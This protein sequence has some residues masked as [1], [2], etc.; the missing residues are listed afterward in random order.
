[1][2]GGGEGGR[3]W[4][5]WEEVERV[6]GGGEG[7]RRWRG[8]EEVERVGGGGEGGRRCGIPISTHFSCNVKVIFLV[9][10]EQFKELNETAERENHYLRRE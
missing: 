2:G 9:V 8:W 3:R 4:R 5:G 6:G 7:G 1:M 10:I